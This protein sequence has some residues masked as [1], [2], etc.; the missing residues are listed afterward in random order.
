[1]KIPQL[2]PSFRDREYKQRNFDE[3]SQIVHTWL[4]RT[5]VGHREIDR[6]ILGLDPLNSKGW[7]SMGV[8]HFLGLKKE[9]KGIFAKTDLQNSIKLLEEDHQDFNIIIE[10]LENATLENDDILITSLFETGKSR[11]KYFEEHY[12]LRLSELENTDGSVNQTQSRK[13]QGILRAILFKYSK[14]TKCAVCHKKLPT[15]L[16]VAAHIKPRS[17]CST[18]EKK[19]PYVVMP[20]CKI[21]CDDFFEKGF[22]IIDSVGEICI[23]TKINYSADLKAI[24]SVYEGKHCTHFN[25]N[26]EKFFEY[27]RNSFYIS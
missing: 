14:E 23:N 15:E 8:L 1:M 9:F 2:D 6:D 12:H 11:D 22:L 4:F 26:T 18:S 25:E 5:D 19:N 21:G 20:V 16:M 24:L 10:L 7:Q 17:K 13:E 3:I 27:R